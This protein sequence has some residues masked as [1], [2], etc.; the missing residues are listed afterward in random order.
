LTLEERFWSKV[1]R[2]ADDEC[3]IWHGTLTKGYGVLS[4]GGKGLGNVRAHRAAYELLIGPNPDN[5]HHVCRNKACVNPAHLERVTPGEHN[6]RHRKCDHVE[7]RMRTDGRSFCPV[8]R[9]EQER[10]RW[11]NPEFR[12]RIAARKRARRLSDPEWREKHRASCRA[13][14]YAHKVAEP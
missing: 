14:Y 7:R 13:Y 10:E 6:T 8:C 3:W 9:L 2:G 4:R 12:A 11:K 5:L 1:E